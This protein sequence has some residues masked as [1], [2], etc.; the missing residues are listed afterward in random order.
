[1][2]SNLRLLLL[3]IERCAE[4]TT[5]SSTGGNVFEEFGIGNDT[6]VDTLIGFV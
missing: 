3:A 2:F 6:M 4:Q 5:L 1:L